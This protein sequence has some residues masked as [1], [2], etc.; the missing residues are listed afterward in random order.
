MSFHGSIALVL[1]LLYDVKVS[2]ILCC[3]IY[4]TNNIQNNKKNSHTHTLTYTM[5]VENFPISV[6][7]RVIYLFKDRIVCCV[8][9]KTNISLYI[10]INPFKMY[11]IMKKSKIQIGNDV[12]KAASSVQK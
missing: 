10:S 12:E 8:H 7:K 6:Y 3:I 11:S 1:L 9:L 2:S 4:I 5:R